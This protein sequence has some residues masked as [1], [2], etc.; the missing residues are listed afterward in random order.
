MQSARPQAVDSQDSSESASR[1][2]GPAPRHSRRSPA[3]PGRTWAHP[4]PLS[5]PCVKGPA[6]GALTSGCRGKGG[7]LPPE[8]SGLTYPGGQVKVKVDR[9]QGCIRREGT[10]EAAPEA[11]RQAVGGGCQSGWG[12]LLSVT[13]AIVAGTCRQGDSGWAQ[14]GRPGGGGGGSNASLDH[15]I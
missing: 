7:G 8:H 14:A 10:A 12:R 6:T 9:P 2:S 1:C 5:P 13:N 3:V 4:V 15:P 11:V